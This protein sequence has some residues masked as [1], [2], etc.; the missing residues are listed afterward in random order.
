MW[1]FRTIADRLKAMFVADVA[2]DFEAQFLAC[3]AERKAEL[4]RQAQRYDDEGLKG[5]AQDLRQQTES[6]GTQRP[7]ASVLPAI[8]HW[9]ATEKSLFPEEDKPTVALLPAPVASVP[10][11]T[12]SVPTRPITNKKRR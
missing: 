4:L 3:D 1:L 9:Q 8:E 7:L 10:T 2:T 6:L 11:V 12:A 5:V